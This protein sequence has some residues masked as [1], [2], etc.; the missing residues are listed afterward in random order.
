MIY[1][2]G[3]LI[4][5]LCRVDSISEG[6][7]ATLIG[8]SSESKLGSLAMVDLGWGKWS[9]DTGLRKKK[10][11]RIWSQG[12]NIPSLPPSQKNYLATLDI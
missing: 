4:Q 6:N 5:Y 7:K 11:S 1:G 9:L 8:N 3:I 12:I 2:C 10:E